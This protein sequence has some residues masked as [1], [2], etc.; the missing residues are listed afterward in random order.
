M[1]NIS[2]RTELDA[3]RARLAGLERLHSAARPCP[4]AALPC[5]FPPIDRTLPWRGLPRGCLHE[6]SGAPGDAATAGFAAAVLSRFA[7]H[8]PIVWI[9]RIRELYAP[10]LQ[11]LGLA[12]QRLMLVH[13]ARAA[14]A[15][16]AIEEALRCAALAAVIA[17]IDAVDMTRSRR[18]QLAAETSG[19][20]AFLLQNETKRAGTSVARTRWRVAALPSAAARGVGAPRWR[21]ELVRARGGATGGWNVEWRNGQ[22]HAANDVGVAADAADR[23]ARAAAPGV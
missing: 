23:P 6:I 9:T 10:G 2:C 5:G 21:V 13:I 11:S 8:G 19:V 3:L 1:N 17:E 15:L 14:D 7:A 4:T 18:L 20:T 12:P 16:W 22:W